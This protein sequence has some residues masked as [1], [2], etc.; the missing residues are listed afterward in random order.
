[1]KWGLNPVCL[2]ISLLIL[3]SFLAFLIF[4]T[5]FSFFSNY[6]TD[7]I[8]YIVFITELSKKFESIGKFQY[9]MS[10]RVKNES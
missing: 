1:M 4:F 9:K 5:F 7:Y 10:I 3:I 8:A 2:P 6:Y